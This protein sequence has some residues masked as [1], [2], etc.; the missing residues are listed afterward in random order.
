MIQR[1][2]KKG[3][4]EVIDSHKSNYRVASRERRDTK[5]LYTIPDSLT[6]KE[7][8]CIFEQSGGE[9]VFLDANETLVECLGVIE[10]WAAASELG[11]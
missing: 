4:Y 7:R 10:T 9:W 11:L 5:S 6:E 8:W 3:L 2:I 1:R